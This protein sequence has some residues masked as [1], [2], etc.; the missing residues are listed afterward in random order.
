MNIEHMSADELMCHL[1]YESA[2]ETLVGS[3][4]DVTEWFFHLF[5]ADHYCPLFLATGVGRSG[6]RLYFLCTGNEHILMDEKMFET[7]HLEVA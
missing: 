2:K 6:N 1:T 7:L 3:R 5:R 4:P